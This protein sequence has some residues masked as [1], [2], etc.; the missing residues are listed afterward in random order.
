MSNRSRYEDELKGVEAEILRISRENQAEH[1][2][3]SADEALLK[4][5][6]DHPETFRRQRALEDAITVEDIQLRRFVMQ[7]GGYQEVTDQALPEAVRSKMESDRS[8]GDG[9]ALKLVASENPGL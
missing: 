7:P 9:R 1:P 5:A 8:L 6:E 2:A 4:T 3:M